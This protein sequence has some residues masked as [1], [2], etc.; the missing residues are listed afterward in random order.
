MRWI[1]RYWVVI[2]C[3]NG[4]ACTAEPSIDL[5]D[6]DGWKIVA[7]EDDPYF[8][9]RSEYETCNPLGI[10]NE[11]GILE[12]QTDVCPFVTLWQPALAD[13]KS[14]RVLTALTYHSA[15]FSDPPGQGMMAIH[16]NEEKIWSVDVAIPGEADVY[17]E[18]FDEY[19][20]LSKGDRILFHVRN[21]GANSWKFAYF[22]S[23]IP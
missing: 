5:V 21:H 15:L 23:E 9:E 1:Q 12:V 14:P 10:T 17:P 11:A 3:L 8:E 22:R 13:S 7:P 16:V 4:L 19:P 2:T 18:V 20:A 6:P